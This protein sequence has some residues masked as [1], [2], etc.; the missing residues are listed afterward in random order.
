M[1]ATNHGLRR[2]DRVSG[3]RFVGMEPL[4]RAWVCHDPSE[5][6]FRRMCATFDALFTPR[7]RNAA[8]A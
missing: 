6:A 7:P 8:V 2:G 3:G 1:K 4:G 5:L